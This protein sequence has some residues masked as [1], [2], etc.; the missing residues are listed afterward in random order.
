VQYASGG[1]G[2]L[3]HLGMEYLLRRLDLRMEHVP[4]RSGPL[5]MQDVMGGRIQVHMGNA[6]D[7]MAAQQAGTIRMIAVTGA[8]RSALIPDVPTVA[9][10]GFPGFELGTWNGMAAPAGTPP[11]V[12]ARI[13]GIMRQACGDAGVREALLR[14]GTDPVC[15]TPEEM[16]AS[17]RRLTPVMREAIALSGATVN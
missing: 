13:A 10:Q 1:T 9:E 17:M 8:A 6:L 2:G 3:S 12:V 14:I 11:A 15:S 4:Y 16:A 5:A 7:M